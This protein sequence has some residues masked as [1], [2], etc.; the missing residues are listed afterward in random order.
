MESQHIPP[1][2]GVLGVLGSLTIGEVNSLIGIAVGIAT[3]VYLFI[4]IMKEIEDG[5]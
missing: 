1:A 3:L 2:I 4:R 5:K